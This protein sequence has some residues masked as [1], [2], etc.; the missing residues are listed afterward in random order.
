MRGEKHGGMG[1]GG[2]RKQ[3]GGMGVLG[4]GGWVVVGWV[5]ELQ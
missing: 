5:R 3:A 2:Q 1:G 4:V